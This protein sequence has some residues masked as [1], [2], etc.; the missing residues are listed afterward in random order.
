MYLPKGII[1]IFLRGLTIGLK[2]LL[3]ILLIK[4]IDIEEYGNFGL[5]QSTTILLTFVVGFDFYAF[6]SREILNKESRNIGFYVT[7]QLAFYLIGYFLVIPAL[8]IISK[9][10][11][12]NYEYIY[13]VLGIV[14]TEHLSQ[15]IYRVLI[16]LKK[17]ITATIVLF[18]RSGLWILMLFLFWKF[19]STGITLNN[20]LT[21]WL[22]GAILSILMGV[23]Y[24]PIKK[25]EKLDFTWIKMGVIISLPFLAGTLMYKIIEFSGRYFLE[26]YW[27]KEEVG[28]FTFFSSVANIL[29]VF[30]QT[31]VIIELYPRLLES[32]MEG[33]SYFL[34]NLRKLESEVIKFTSIGIVLSLIL[35]YPL[36][37]F[38]EEP[39]LISNLYSYIILLF[40][41]ALF[42]ISFISHYA[43]Y[44]YHKDNQILFSTTVSFIANLFFSFLLIPKFGI[45]GASVS[46]L[47]SYILMLVLKNYYWKKQRNLK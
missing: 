27:G 6:S 26:F 9:L 42:C 31:I 5:I 36:V 21:F 10:N 18:I 39:L 7:N 30:V 2:F 19:G 22:I 16:L 13:Y 45:M 24:L 11:I 41:T 40:S 23:K 44:T 14:I 29:F 8:F 34:Q 15:E 3:S 37:K 46:Q 43:L 12:I 47:I 33:E 35:I 17:T 20:V 38:L 4:V 25:F 1:N 32:L 28:I